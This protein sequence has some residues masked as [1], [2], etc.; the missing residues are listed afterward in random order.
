[1]G[2]AVSVVI[3]VKRA[4]PSLRACLAHLAAQTYRNF[5]VY[6]VPDEPA[7]LDDPTVRVIASGPALPN[8]KRRI[9]AVASA[10]DVVA[11]IDDDAYPDPGWLAAAVGPFADPAVVAAG[12]PAVTPPSASGRERASGAIYASRLVTATTRDR[13]VAGVRHDVAALPSCNLLMRRTAFLR[14]VRTSLDVWPGE[15]ILTCLE[16]TRAGGRIVYEP[17]A[18]VFHHRRP[19]FAAHLTQVWRYAFFRGG[20]LRRDRHA[21]WDAAHAVP[22]AFVLAHPF[23]AAAIAWPRTRR[24]G[25]LAAGTYAMLAGLDAVREARAARANPATVAAGIYLTHLTYGAGSIAGFAR[26]GR[27]RAR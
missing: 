11:F 10:A 6:V 8:R 26:S 24:A 1:M 27:E 17:A 19:V 21:G 16:A 12:G 15:D 7:S 2:P 18:R 3:P 5:D 25:L 23:V 13:Y 14:A 22:A 4:G 20:F 9:A